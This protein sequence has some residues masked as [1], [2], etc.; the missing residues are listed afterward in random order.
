MT[1]TYKSGRKHNDADCL[2]R[3]PL[4]EAHSNHEDDDGFLGLITATAMASEQY[5]DPELKPLIDYLQH[6]TDEVPTIFRR[7]IPSFSI[8]NGV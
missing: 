2:L 5:S 6:R 4:E 7:S 8:H 1:V 3:A